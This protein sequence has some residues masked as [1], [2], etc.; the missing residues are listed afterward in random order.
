MSSSGGTAPTALPQHHKPVRVKLSTKKR[1]RQALKTP[2][3]VASVFGDD[4]SDATAGLASDKA[5]SA[6]EDRVKALRQRR[7]EAAGAAQ[8]QRQA[9]GTQ[10]S[11]LALAQQLDSSDSS[12]SSSGKRGS[13]VMRATLAVACPCAPESLPRLRARIP[14]H[15]M[16]PVVTKAAT[17]GPKKGAQVASP[18]LLS[19]ITQR[20]V[21]VGAD[22]GGTTLAVATTRRS[23]VRSG[24][25]I[26]HVVVWLR[27]LAS[28]AAAATAAT[29]T[30]AA[31]AVVRVQ[32]AA[33]SR[34]VAQFSSLQVCAVLAVKCV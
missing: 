11:R 26:D 10:G 25:R 13:D 20:K 30:A 14:V 12:D 2:Q 23:L 8:P 19:A 31:D 1:P 7:M 24:Q 18:G 33:K 32:L 15:S 16:A 3:G 21:T 9:A 27:P 22:G 5:L 29:A 28:T 4:T 6:W 34:T 17:A